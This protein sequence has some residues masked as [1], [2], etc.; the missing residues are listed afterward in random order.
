MVMQKL[1]LLHEGGI[2]VMSSYFQN[3][4]DRLGMLKLCFVHM[5]C[6]G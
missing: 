1:F 5:E 2:G 6:L 4:V 3:T